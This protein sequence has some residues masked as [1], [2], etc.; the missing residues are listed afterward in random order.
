VA[1]VLALVNM[2]LERVRDLEEK[3]RVAGEQ[4]QPE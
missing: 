3:L 1:A 2:L 4:K